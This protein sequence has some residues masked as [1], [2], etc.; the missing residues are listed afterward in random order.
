MI[1]CDTYIFSIF[2]GDYYLLYQKEIN[3]KEKGRERELLL[4]WAAKL[5]HNSSLTQRKGG[6]NRMKMAQE[7]R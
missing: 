7:L 4:S 5:H 1:P 3:E 6:E 2:L